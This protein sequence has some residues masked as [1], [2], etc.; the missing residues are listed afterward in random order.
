M[1]FKEDCTMRKVV[2]CL[3]LVFALTLTFATLVTPVEAAGGLGGGCYFTCDCAGTP[4]KCCPN[5]SGG[6]S[7]KVTDEW[8]C[9]QVYNC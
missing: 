2:L 8:A 4:L 1:G 3:A 7:C 6:Y 5:L 9:P